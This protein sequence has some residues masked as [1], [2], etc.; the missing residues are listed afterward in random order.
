[1]KLTVLGSGTTVPHPK[2]SSSG[3]WL[4][5]SGG[6]ALLDI[7]AAMPLRMAQEGVDWPGLDTIWIS[8]FHLD[9]CGGLPILLQGIKH[10]P[11]IK[12]RTKPLRILGPS[13]TKRLLANFE[14]VHDYK[15]QKQSFPVDVVEVDAGEPFEL[16]SGVDAVAYKTRHTDESLAVRITDKG[17][18]IVY[19]ADTAFDEIIAT[20]ANGAD[21]FV[22]E[23][24]FV[25][26]KPQ[27]K[28]V[29]L[30]EAIYLI[31]R[32]KAK[33]ALLTHLSQAWDTVDFDLEVRK[34]DPFM[35][36]VTAAYD[37]LRIEI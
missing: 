11:Q 28:H 36:N 5:T 37:G 2:R 29:E 14:A 7:S 32:S 13:G 30:A 21:L 26:N 18:S 19:S 31:R 1:M 10:A 35:T 8:H 33:K 17:R 25:A 6:T 12:G 15:L 3:Y 4:E 24:T 23:C 27:E 9:H 16:V 20:F 34:I 22:L